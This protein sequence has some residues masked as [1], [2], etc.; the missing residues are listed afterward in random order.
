MPHERGLLAALELQRT[1]N[2]N[3]VET[4]LERQINPYSANDLVL[5]AFYTGKDR[6]KYQSKVK[7]V[8]GAKNYSA[9]EAELFSMV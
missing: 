4:L 5:G 3:D 8:L 1:F 6:N 2:T 9:I 7:E